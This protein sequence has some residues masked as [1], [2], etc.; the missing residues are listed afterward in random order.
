MIERKDLFTI[1]FY[2]KTHFS[3]SYQGMHYRIE[4]TETNDNILLCATVFPGPYCFDVVPEEQKISHTF[5]FSDEGICEACKW[6]NEQY[7]AS[8]EEWAKGRI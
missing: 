3:G 7:A 2:K 4:R 1:P 8:P 6:L 5:D